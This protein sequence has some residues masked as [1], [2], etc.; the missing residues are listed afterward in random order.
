MSKSITA[1][2]VCIDDNLTFDT[3]VDNICLKASRQISA[4]QRLIGLLDLSSRKAIDT[5]FIFQILIIALWCGFSPAGQV[6][7]KYRNS[8]SVHFVSFLKILLQITKH[9]YPR[10]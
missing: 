10:G 4:L 9:Y 3:H 8:R 6:L 2:G 5:S 1:L 7:L